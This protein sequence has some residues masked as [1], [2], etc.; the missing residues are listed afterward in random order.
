[1]GKDCDSCR[2][3]NGNVVCKQGHYRASHIIIPD[4]HAY[5]EVEKEKWW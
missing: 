1:M 5:K 4:C 2:F 3:E